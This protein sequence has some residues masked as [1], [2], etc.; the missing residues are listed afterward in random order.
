MRVTH[1]FPP[2]VSHELLY[3]RET[4]P[5][6]RSRRRRNLRRRA[7]Q[8]AVKPVKKE[9][10]IIRGQRLDAMSQIIYTNTKWSD[11][12]RIMMK[13]MKSVEGEDDS[14]VVMAC[15]AL[16]VESQLEDYT[17]EQLKAGIKGSSE[18]IALYA[19]TLDPLSSLVPR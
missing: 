14:D 4:L 5:R 15:L 3:V 10:V 11:V 16:A 18:W 6:V 17:M 9:P 19:S 13:V 12:Q 2:V 8:E 7:N 1:V